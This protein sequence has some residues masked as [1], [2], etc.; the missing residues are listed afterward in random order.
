LGL[1]VGAL[2][3]IAWMVLIACLIVA[4]LLLALGA[5]IAFRGMV[6]GVFNFAGGVAM[7]A[8]S[9]L[10][11]G[12]WMRSVP[13][14]PSLRVRDGWADRPCSYRKRDQEIIPRRNRGLKKAEN[15]GVSAIHGALFLT[16]VE[17]VLPMLGGSSAMRKSEAND[18]AYICHVA[19]P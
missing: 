6:F 13:S 7:L 12:I 1:F 16:L 11:G 9:V 5:T 3:A 8:E 14:R 10:A 18:A 17:P 2:A 19:S 4:D 15:E